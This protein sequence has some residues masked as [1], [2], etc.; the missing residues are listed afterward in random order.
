MKKDIGK[1]AGVVAVAVGMAGLGIFGV[2]H[3]GFGAAEMAAPKPPAKSDVMVVPLP[4]HYQ[5]VSSVRGAYYV[6][7][8][9]SWYVEKSGPQDVQIYPD[10]D[11]AEAALPICKIDL[12]VVD[13]P[14]NLVLEDWIGERLSAD[15]TADVREVSAESRSAGGHP[16]TIWSGT[17][18]GKRDVVA[19]VGGVGKVYELALS[20]LSDSESDCSED[21]DSV[22]EGFSVVGN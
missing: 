7:T 10:Y 17:V 2:M 14:R 13:N 5:R 16:A 12:S 21:L 22:L 19:Y 20:N 15:P 11:P 8:P 3:Y 18:D 1:Y 9:S 4:D 6:K